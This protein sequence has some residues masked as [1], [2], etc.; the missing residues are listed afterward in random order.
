MNFELT[1]SK[2]SA[3]QTEALAVYVF[4]KESELKGV[5]RD[6]DRATGGTIGAFL[7]SKEFTGK[8]YDSVYLR[9][10]QGLQAKRL[11]VFGA[12]KKE[13]FDLAQLRR[14]VGA[15]ARTFRARSIPDFALL[16][17]S[18]FDSHE[19][20]QAVVEGVLL[21]LFDIDRY[22]TDNEDKHSIQ[23]VRLVGGD[24]ARKSAILQ[25]IERG[26]IVAESQNLTRELINEP[27]NKMTP[28][29]LAERAR[30]LAS[31]VGLTVE[32]LER[33]DA[34]KAGMGAFL[35]VA[36]GSN[37]P[38]KFIVLT[39]L[40]K[41]VEDSSKT[42]GLVG[43]GITFDAGGISLKPADG[44]EK[45]KYDMSGAATILG[46]MRAIALLKPKVKVVAVIPATENMPGGKAQKPGDVHT[47]MSGKTIE[48]INTD[49]EG[50]LV[51]ADG[52]CYARKIGATHLVDVATLTGAISVALGDVRVGVFGNHEKWT[53][54][55]L[56]AAEQCGEKM[57]PMPLDEE[58][59]EQIK[60]KIADLKNSG[61]R[62]GGAS[63]GAKF[64]EAF[65]ES[66]PWVHLDI[67]GTG[68]LEEG[69]PYCSAGPT[70][71][72]VRSLIQ[73]VCSQR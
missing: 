18:A 16:K 36:Q 31:D 63:I 21:G 44:M 61:P 71:V 9:N 5:L 72:S 41:P 29:I 69:K 28:T 20:A 30:R 60:S 65:V 48:V 6:V 67:A 46:V 42:I 43:K 25:A 38:P 56:R 37:E 32:I 73:L 24:M 23:T 52:L 68:W 10:P 49:A 40:P 34:E 14:L 26:R 64:L 50:R 39:Y 3:V 45:M 51:L 35:S 11:F 59:G 7:A 15:M 22:K 27:S 53:H 47:A 19:A 62:Q 8:L 57:W 17:R 54:L 2:F 4:E 1:S 58:Y 33:A 70:G 12:G 13:D 55:V 66:V